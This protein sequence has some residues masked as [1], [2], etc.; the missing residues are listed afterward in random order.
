[1]REM[2]GRTQSGAAI[3][4]TE[5]SQFQNI[6]GLNHLY[7]NGS[8]QFQ[9]AMEDLEQNGRRVVSSRFTPAGE[10]ARDYAS[11]FYRSLA[12]ATGGQ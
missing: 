10:H 4:P 2:Y 3:S 1:M 11:Y 12:G 6:M 5:W 8:A 7:L 9:A